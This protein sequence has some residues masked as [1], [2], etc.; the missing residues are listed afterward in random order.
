M[1][2]RASVESLG[3]PQSKLICNEEDVQVYLE[4]SGIAWML[5][6]MKDKSV[7]VLNKRILEQMETILDSIGKYIDE[8]QIRVLA[9]VS[10]KS[11]SFIAGA[12]IDMLYQ[13]CDKNEAHKLVM[14][15]N[16][17]MN[18]IETLPI[19]VVAVINGAA[20]GGG[21][22]LALCCS[23]RI[24]LNHSSCQL[25]LPE[26]KIGLI[27][28]AGG[29]FRLPRLIGLQNSLEIILNGSSLKVKKAEKLGLIDEIIDDPS[30][31]FI[32]SRRY[33]LISI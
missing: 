9:I 20:L 3:P 19:P 28:G 8:S 16:I 18:R 22:E 12:D 30:S 21:L 15:G 23:H 26:V 13:I 6:D 25:G 4:A 7:N 29:T 33:F 24:A 1:N 32:N 10:A 2:A 11:F 14:K 17:V 27:P 5:C 31:F